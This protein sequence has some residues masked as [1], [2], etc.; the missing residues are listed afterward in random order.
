MLLWS[1]V[2]LTHSLSALCGA[3]LGVCPTT[4]LS[5]WTIQ[6]QPAA[7]PL[8]MMQILRS[9]RAACAQARKV[10]TP[11]QAL[12]YF[13]CRK[14]EEDYLYEQDWQ[15]FLEAGALS[16]LRVAFSRAQANKVGACWPEEPGPEM[17]YSEACN[18]LLP[19]AC[20]CVLHSTALSGCES[21]QAKQRGTRTQHFAPAGG[22]FQSSPSPYT[23]TDILTC[24]HMSPAPCAGV[25]AAP[26][27]GGRSRGGQA[28]R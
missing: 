9:G 15:D 12:L 27:Q 11:G 22:A 26:A 10:N 18:L 24:V 13:G 25:C 2:L 5:G 1:P 8:K 6:Q 19:M 7:N 28:H 14:P 21:A 20:V 3:G 17:L 23:G 4:T 16:K